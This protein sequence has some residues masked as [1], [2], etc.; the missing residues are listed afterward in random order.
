M[1]NKTRVRGGRSWNVKTPGI[2]VACAGA[3]RSLVP[4]TPFRITSEGRNV[5]TWILDGTE[6]SVTR[7][8]ADVCV[9]W[10]HLLFELLIHLKHYFGWVNAFHEN[11][12]SRGMI[13]KGQVGVSVSPGGITYLFFSEVCWSIFLMLSIMLRDFRGVLLLEKRKHE[14]LYVFKA[15]KDKKGQLKAFKWNMCIK[16]NISLRLF[17]FVLKQT[18]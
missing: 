2:R 8:R 6:R 11:I 1:Q 17:I 14:T 7:I 18:A 3:S 12:K 16:T 13:I 4:T 9:L 5:L 10:K 15:V